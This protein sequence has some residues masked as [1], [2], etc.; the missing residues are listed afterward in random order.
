MKNISKKLVALF[1]SV[2]ML[3]S[4]GTVAFA[5]VEY[6]IEDAYAE[7]AELYPEFVDRIL[8]EGVTEDQ[9]IAFLE[10]VQEYLLNLN[11]EV[12]EENFEEH[13]IGAVNQT[14]GLR[15]HRF[16]RDALIEAF[17]EAVLEGAKGNISDEFLPLVETIKAIIFGNGMLDEET[18]PTE[19]ETVPTEEDTTEPTEAPTEKESEPTEEA[20]EAPTE[21]ET[22]KPTTGGGG[23]GGFDVEDAEDVTEAPTEKPTAPKITFSD[24]N[25]APWAE[26]AVYALADRRI[27]NGYPDGTFKPNNPVTRAEFSKIIV[28]VSGRY[29]PAVETYTSNFTDVPVKDWSYSYVSAAHKFGFIKGRSET[30]FDPNSNITRADL[31]LIVYRYIKTLNSEFKAKTNADGTP[32]TFADAASVPVWDVEAVNALYS[33]GVAPLRDVANNKFDPTAP[34][35]RAE[36]ALIVYNATNV[37]LGLPITK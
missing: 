14:I 15:Q 8:A 6:S 26:K 17:P 29:T 33:N 25:Q 31:C 19:E 36:C 2:V 3:L 34:A 12:T 23:G 9:I 16:V 5:G 27:I 1:L 21:E 24:M 7:C 10:A 35:T 13:I 28:L 11:E 22:K 37:A 20:T 4:M 18:E 30:I 32:I